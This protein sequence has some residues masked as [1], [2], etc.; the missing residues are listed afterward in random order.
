MTPSLLDARTIST[1]RASLDAEA[2]GYE[3]HE[4]IARLYPIC[5][6]ITGDGV[7]ETLRLI[8]AEIDLRTREVPTG[9]RVFDWTVPKEWNIRD[10]YIKDSRGRRV[11][12]FHECNLH[13]VNYSVGV[14]ERLSLEELRPRLFTLPERPDWIPYKTSYYKE[15]WGFCLTQRQFE[16]LEEGTYDVRIDASLTDGHLT[17]GECCIPGRTGDEVMLSAHTC[18]PSL[19]NDNLAA[20]SIAVTLAKLLAQVPLRLSYR[21]LFNPGTI[22]AITWLALNESH[23]PNVVHGL[24]LA[25]LGD[26]GK[27]H[28]KR[29]RRGDATIDRVMSHVLKQSGTDYDVRDF[30]PEGY[31]ERQFCSPGFNLPVGVLSRTPHG[32]FPEYHTSADN[33]DLV[34][35]E[36]LA[37]S[38]MKLLSAIEVLEGDGVFVNC[39]PKCEPQLGARGLYATMG[40]YTDASAFQSA[41][42]WVLN[43]SD[44]TSSLL[45]VAERSR[46]PFAMV[47]EAADALIAAG[48]LTDRGE[49]DRLSSPTTR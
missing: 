47:R 37:D 34:A 8:G 43:M 1:L 30:T 29:S 14:D 12:D 17:L 3:M 18:H 22:G 23:V 20:I 40:G 26:R 45:G 21:F 49:G 6:S 32:R 9:T 15:T 16:R 5:R 41:L 33:L 39:N 13:V 31:D 7:R 48:L 42:L 10:A 46:L 36:A 25:C 11:V 2:L 44:G 27:T 4:R 38:L 35:P 19:C 24:V 28:Y